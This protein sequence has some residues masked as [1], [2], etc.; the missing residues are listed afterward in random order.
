MTWIL[1]LVGLGTVIGLGRWRDG[2]LFL[3]LVGFLQ[4][5]IRKILP[6]FPVYTQVT[7]VFFLG[8]VVL[9]AI[10][11]NVQ[12]RI[13]YIHGGEQRLRQAWNLYIFL[14]LAQCG[15]AFVLY[16]NPVLAG[17]GILNYGAPMAGII[18]GV[19]FASNTQWIH[20]FLRTYVCLAVPVAL[21]IY[22]SFYFQDN[23][24]VLKSIGRLSGHP[25]LIYDQGGLLYS[26]SGLMRVGEIAAWHAG[27]AVM[28]L[29]MFGVRNR[30]LSFRIIAGVAS[31]LLI[32]A[33]VLTGRRKM[34]MAVAIFLAVF[35]LVMMRYWRGTNR[36]T[37]LI[38]VLS[39]CVTVYVWLQ[40]E[41]GVTALYAARGASVF[42]DAT[43]RL[44][45]A[46]NLLWAGYARGGI[47]G[48]G[49]GLSAQGSQYFGAGAADVGGAA[50]GGGGK[51][52]VELGVIG[53]ILVVY[54]VWRLFR[55]F[56]AFLRMVPAEDEY[57]SV[58]LAALIAIIIA[59]GTTFLVATQVFG[60]TFVLVLMGF[61]AGFLFA[62]ER[63]AR[64]L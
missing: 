29:I 5:P 42:E 45:E 41:E 6:G 2:V 22:L 51:I 50:E 28:L 9:C 18:V 17:L 57:L 1:P 23:W 10:L 56:D 30:Q 27:T 44:V 36:I 55:H 52:V 47:F 46:W 20:R 8:I 13:S 37:A 12:F 63:L 25:L 62:F 61:F 48:L 24:D 54:L 33:I 34:I 35:V 39:L 49:A 64:G 32:G 4:D 7:V 3:I 16:G 40:P 15:H 19:A 11:Q 60:D 14:I 26:N 59:N 21:T 31:V 58:T 53:L 43:A 38:A